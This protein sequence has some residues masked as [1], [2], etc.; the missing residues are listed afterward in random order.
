MKAGLLLSSPSSFRNI[1]PAQNRLAPFRTLPSLRAIIPFTSALSLILVQYITPPINEM[2]RIC[3][4]YFTLPQNRLYLRILVAKTGNEDQYYTDVQ[5][6]DIVR[7]MVK[8]VAPHT[9]T[10]KRFATYN[11]LLDV[12]ALRKGG[13]K[14]WR[15]DLVKEALGHMDEDYD[16]VKKLAKKAN[17]PEPNATLTLP[18]VEVEV[19]KARVKPPIGKAKPPSTRGPVRRTG[20]AHGQDSSKLNVLPKDLPVINGKPMSE[21]Q[22]LNM[23]AATKL[24]V[25]PSSKEYS[26]IAINDMVRTMLDLTNHRNF[27]QIVMKHVDIFRNQ[28]DHPLTAELARFMTEG[29]QTG[30]CRNAIELLKESGYPGARERNP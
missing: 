19:P 30:F 14:V 9:F 21:N 17:V 23:Y 7:E 12:K 15:D 20:P 24:V 13:N 26:A 1:S 27:P 2:V 3:L 18:E 11:V 6:K 25:E 10:E 28:K 22:L 29:R 16:Q 4:H 5:V 8:D